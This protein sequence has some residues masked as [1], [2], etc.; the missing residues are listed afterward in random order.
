MRRRFAIMVLNGN[1]AQY[2]ALANVHAQVSA[3]DHVRNEK[4]LD[5]IEAAMGP[6]AGADLHQWA[7][8]LSCLA[9]S[10]AMC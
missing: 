10:S 6:G 7:V 8:D 4:H 2:G 1:A 5:E 3:D 9:G